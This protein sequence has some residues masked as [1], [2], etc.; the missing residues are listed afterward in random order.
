M[1]TALF[2]GNCVICQTTRI[3]I[4]ALDWFRQVEF[5]D[6]HDTARIEADYPHMEKS[7]LMGEI[8]VIDELGRVYVGFAGTRRL[9]RSVPLGIPLWA[10][11]HL[12][13]FSHLG[14]HLY[15]FIA[16]NRYAINRLFGVNL[17][18][19]DCSDGVCRVQEQG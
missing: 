2:D 1:V 17:P 10:L 14:P 7:A 4:T 13:G 6:V 8:H 12:P 18:E 11:F 15:R 19:D 16:R 3:L 5:V 9:L